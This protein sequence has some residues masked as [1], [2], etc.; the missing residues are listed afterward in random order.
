M[1]RWFWLLLLPILIGV[2]GWWG[3]TQ[4]ALTIGEPHDS[5]YLEGFHAR[6]TSGGMRWRWTTQAAR[7]TL[8]L[9]HGAVA[10]T[11]QG[12]VAPAA[13]YVT[14]V[15]PGGAVS[16]PGP[17]TISGDSAPVL[18]QYMV[19]LAPTPSWVGRTDIQFISARG[20]P[21]ITDQRI[22]GLLLRFVNLEGL[23]GSP[24]Q[25]P[26]G[27]L[28]SLALLTIGI[29]LLLRLGMASQGM[30]V[31]GATCIGSICAWAWGWHRLWVD[32]YLWVLV[33]ASG[34]IIGTV[35]G[36]RLRTTDT[37]SP[38]KLYGLLMAG[39]VSLVLWSFARYGWA[40]VWSWRGLPLL[41]F[42][43]AFLLVYAPTRWRSGI[44]TVAMLVALAFAAGSYASIWHKDWA[45]DFAPL[46]R[47][48]RAFW[49]GQGL[50]QLADISANRFS[51]VYKYPPFFAMIMWPF[52]HLSPGPAFQTWKVVQALLIGVSAV[53]LW[54][55]ETRDWRRWSTLWLVLVVAL[56][57]PIIDALRYGQVDAL[58]LPLL[59]T[60]LWAI[61]RERWAVFGALL[62]VAALIKLY[63]A[64]LLLLPLLRKRWSGLWGF[65]GAGMGLTALALLI[66]GPAVHVTYLRDVLPLSGGGTA[67]VEN[68]TIN[69]FLYRLINTTA[70]T[71][72]PGNNAIIEWATYG[73]AVVVTLL[74][75][76]WSREL[77]DDVAYALLITS[78][79]IVLPV[80]W[81]H[82]QTL[83][84]IPLYVVFVQ[85]ERSGGLRWSRAVPLVMA[86]A[87]LCFG[88]QWTFFDRVMYGPFWQFILSYKLYGLV[89]LFGVIGLPTKTIIARGM[90]ATSTRLAAKVATPI[91]E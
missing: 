80:A 85:A 90:G 4:I 91:Y 15:V 86:W 8:P 20:E 22:L 3:D 69:G 67:W 19:F 54:F 57:Q 18:R 46:Y 63:P 5:R 33:M 83:L 41:L 11:L 45:T 76:W 72:A 9:L 14:M 65:L 56:F 74:A 47:G 71:L 51:A 2:G 34:W 42:P 59:A 43:C 40:N 30:A 44:V 73:T 84:L 78:M 35:A 79:L 39:S 32:P 16:L 31:I 13:G 53:M 52:L 58:L 50:Y 26:L 27:P 77:A 88:N 25:L 75:L 66:M 29:W 64:Y 24:M 38:A 10:M 7:L 87:L 1:K 28:I 70:I 48:P 82:Y 17:G 37:V 61:R 81:I 68:Q 60:G 55:A 6:E 62:A 49:Q 36:M 21:G 23:G 12:A 89:L